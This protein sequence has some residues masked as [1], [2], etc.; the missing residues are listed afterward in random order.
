MDNKRKARVEKHR[1][2]IMKQINDKERNR[3]EIRD[4]VHNEGVAIR[5][6]QEQSDKYEEKIIKAKVSIYIAYIYIC[7]KWSFFI[8]Q[9]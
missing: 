4:R 5:M 3:Q 1:Q 2:E 7:I 9:Q 6:E 8:L